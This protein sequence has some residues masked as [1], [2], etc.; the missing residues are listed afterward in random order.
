[1]QQGTT[2]DKKFKRQG[3]TIDNKIMRQGISIDKKIMRQGTTI[4]KKIMRQ[5]TTIDKKIMRQGT[6]I[7]KKIM[8]Q[9]ITIDK[10]I[11]RQGT[12]IDKKIMRQGTTID[13]KIMR[14]GI[15]IDKKIMRQG[16]I[17]KD[18]IQSFLGTMDNVCFW[19]NCYATGY[20]FGVFFATGYRVW[21]DLPHTP[22]TY[23]VIYPLLRAQATPLAR[24]QYSSLFGSPANKLSF[25]RV[26]EI[27]R[28]LS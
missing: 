3:T 14:Q 9:G 11:M 7:D 23:L 18:I 8:R 25:E 12:T 22:V 2:I 13:K 27:W 4:D 16:I 10:K 1:M 6:T 21:R 5:G 26:L 24:L 28:E 17:W 15:T 19:Q 20:A